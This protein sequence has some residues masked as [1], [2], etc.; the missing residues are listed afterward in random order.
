MDYWGNLRGEA[1]SDTSLLDGTEDE[2]FDTSSYVPASEDDEDITHQASH[3]LFLQSLENPEQTFT[4][5]TAGDINNTIFGYAITIHKSQGSEAGKVYV[6]LHRS[7]NSM[8]SRE[9]AYT[10]ITRAKE[11]LYIV[12]EKES[13]VTAAARQ[14]VSGASIYEKANLFKGK[15]LNGLAPSW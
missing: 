6:C 3:I 14:Q 12:C 15:I 2:D 8:L 5:K 1:A 4:L 11:E 10:A 7:H 9:L 13:L